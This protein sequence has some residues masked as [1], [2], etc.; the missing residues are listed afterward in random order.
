MDSKNGLNQKTEGLKASPQPLAKK[1]N[2]PKKS[3]RYSNPYAEE[4]LVMK[5]DAPEYI[6]CWACRNVSSKASM[7][8]HHPGGRV[9]A[10]LL[11]FHYVHRKCHTI[12]HDDEK[13][14]K[15]LGLIT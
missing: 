6:A 10:K 15:R 13:R 4:Y 8:P 7:E 9:G 1:G 5:F 2:L 12:I 14:A 11:V 3:K